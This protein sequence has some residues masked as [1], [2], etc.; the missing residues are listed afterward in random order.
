MQS[1]RSETTRQV[2]VGVSKRYPEVLIMIILVLFC[3]RGSTAEQVRVTFEH[4]LPVLLLS[5]ANLVVMITGRID[6]SLT[7]LMA[8]S[9]VLFVVLSEPVPGVLSALL[10]YPLRSG[11]CLRFSIHCTLLLDIRKSPALKRCPL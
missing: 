1:V 10:R 4:T 3:V 2:L 7:S 5:L 11:S 9:A 8:I 6:L